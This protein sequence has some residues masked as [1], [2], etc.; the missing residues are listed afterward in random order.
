MQRKGQG[1]CF[2]TVKKYMFLENTC[3][4]G[5]NLDTGQLYSTGH[6]HACHYK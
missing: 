2:T 3:F 6:G 5:C 4:G 1:E